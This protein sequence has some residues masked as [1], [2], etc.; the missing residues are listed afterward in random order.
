[1]EKENGRMSEAPYMKSLAA[2]I[3]K[4]VLDGYA[5]DFKATDLGL[6]SVH[7]SRHYFPEE[8]HVVNFFRFEGNSD[9]EDNA[10]MY[11]IE[12]DDGAKGTLVDAYGA[13]ADEN[14]SNIL[15]QVENIRKNI[16]ASGT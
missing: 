15:K 12:T 2:C 13:Y 1:M 7:T 10:I 16:S 6:T 4:M 9:P 14:I 11:V 8:I 5:D 3:N